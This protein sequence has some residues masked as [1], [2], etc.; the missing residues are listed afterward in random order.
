MHKMCSTFFAK[1]GN[2][3]LYSN[4]FWEFRWS[5]KWYSKFFKTWYILF[6]SLFSTN[7]KKQGKIAKVLSSVNFLIFSSKSSIHFFRILMIFK[8]LKNSRISQFF[9]AKLLK[10][11]IFV[12]LR[13]WKIFS[14][15]YFFQET[16][17]FQNCNVSLEVECSLIKILSF[18]IMIS[19]SF[20]LLCANF[21]LKHRHKVM[22]MHET[23]KVWVGELEQMKAKNI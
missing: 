16:E 5:M 10:L 17:I 3:E 13:V 8:N 19:K 12:F 6:V 23:K 14:I 18:K 15:S 9:Q 22:R 2:F 21:F 1:L 11:R 7:M 20:F 4:V